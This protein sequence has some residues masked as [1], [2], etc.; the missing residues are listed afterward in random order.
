MPKRRL[1]LA[2]PLLLGAMGANALAAPIQCADYALSG[3]VM[4]PGY[5]N[6]CAVPAPSTA[7]VFNDRTRNPTDIGYTIDIFGSEGRPRDRQYTFQLNDFAGQSFDNSAQPFIYGADFLP[8]GS[9]YGVISESAGQFPR[10]I[11]L[12][13]SGTFFL[14]G[15]L[16]GVPMGDN[17]NGFAIDPRSGVAY[18]TTSY[19]SPPQARLF[20]V[21]VDTGASTLVGEIDAPTNETVGT[22]MISIAVNCEGRLYGHNI[23]D[24]SLYTIHRTT[25]VAGFVG[26]H[27]L[28]ANF[29]QGMDFDNSTGELY[30]FMMLNSGENRFGLFDLESGG[31][32]TL[33]NNTPP[34][35]FEGAIPTACPAAVSIFAD[36]FE[37]DF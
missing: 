16:V 10:S 20:T 31:F 36:G 27:G 34:G 35:E 32:T 9:F 14:K 12:I 7:V 22:V 28:D 6:A 30:V 2:L 25:A 3:A 1:D 4:P 17:I 24:D 11:G 29:A 26:Q 18:L 15:E 8:N 33:A 37:D 21:N 19:G 5:A 13:H 23:A